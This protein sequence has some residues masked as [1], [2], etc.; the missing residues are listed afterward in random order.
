M[1]NINSLKEENNKKYEEIK[2]LYREINGLKRDIESN[3]KNMQKICC[4]EWETETQM[5]ER[6]VSCKICGLIDWERSRT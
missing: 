4:H 2:N 5:Y 3:T 1:D 6:I